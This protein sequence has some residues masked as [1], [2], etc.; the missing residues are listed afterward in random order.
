MSSLLHLISMALVSLH[1]QQ[2]LPEKDV[3]PVLWIWSSRHLHPA[4]T[5]TRA[6][7]LVGLNKLKHHC[8]ADTEGAHHCLGKA[9][10][11]FSLPQFHSVLVFEIMYMVVRF[12]LPAITWGKISWLDLRHFPFS[13]CS[14]SQ[15]WCGDLW[16]PDSTSAIKASNASWGT[17]LQLPWAQVALSASPQPLL[18]SPA[19][20]SVFLS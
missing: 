15:Q 4:F 11:T 7:V 8:L 2:W 16:W 12:V 20:F 1:P 13:S 10:V 17:Q 18:L 9:L 6:P 14:L 3:H 19:N 5:R